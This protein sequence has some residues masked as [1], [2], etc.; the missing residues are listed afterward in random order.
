MEQILPEV[1]YDPDINVSLDA[2]KSKTRSVALLEFKR[3]YKEIY[4]TDPPRSKL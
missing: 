1:N 2:H 4:G 3:L